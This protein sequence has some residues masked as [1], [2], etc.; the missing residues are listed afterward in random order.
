MN[1]DGSYTYTPDPD[2]NGT[3]S[4]DYQL[5]DVDGDCDI[6]TVTIAVNSVNDFPIANDD[7]FTLNLDGVL[8]ETVADNDVPSGDGGN[9]WTVVNQPANGS[10][11]LNQ[12]GSYTYTPQLN[13]NG[14]DSFTYELCDADGDC[15]E[16]SVSVT[17]VDVVLPNQIFTPNN[18]GQNDTF[19][20][21]GI[22]LYP[23]NRLTIFNRWGNLVYEKSGYLNEWDGYANVKKVG[24]S[25]LPVGTY[26][27]VL[28]YGNNKHKTG[29][30]YLDR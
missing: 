13:F 25:P 28:D 15:D 14:S 17:M 8:N 18:D 30:I 2:F 20:I 29:Y 3:D 22:G 6:A 5:C 10:V 12:D 21:F 4:F 7:E 23:N 26:F 24:N 16:A 27:Y 1:T 19:Y 9:I 11:L